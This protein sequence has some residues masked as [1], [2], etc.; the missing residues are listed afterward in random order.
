MIIDKNKDWTFKNKEIANEFDNHVR[1]QLPWYEMVKKI[2]VFII[3]SYVNTNGLIYDIGCS[4]GNLARALGDIIKARDLKLI[5]I[6]DSKDMLDLYPF[7]DLGSTWCGNALEYDYQEFDVAVLFLVSMFFDTNKREDFLQRLYEKKKKNGII[8]LVDKFVNNDSNY[9]STVMNRFNI[10]LKMGNLIESK[11]ILNK[12]LSLSGIQVPLQ[13]SELPK[14][15]GKGPIE[16]FR[17]GDFRGYVF[18]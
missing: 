15:K 2:I 8:I 4:T 14:G 13:Y 17:V 3:R 6:D 18:L 7:F 9:F 5:G 10:L 1:E 12:E 16:F 11:E